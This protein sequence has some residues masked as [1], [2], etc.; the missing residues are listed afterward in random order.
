MEQL[1]RTDLSAHEVA[2]VMVIVG[3]LLVGRYA[4]EFLSS[5]VFNQ[6]E[7]QELREGVL[8]GV[9]RWL[10]STQ[11]FARA[12]AQLL[13]FKII[14]T[15]VDVGSS[16]DPQLKSN[17]RNAWYL[18][19]VYKYFLENSDAKRLREKQSQF[20]DVFDVEETCTPEG[21]SRLPIDM[22]GEVNPVTMVERIVDCLKGMIDEAEEEFLDLATP[23]PKSEEP[24]QEES[25]V[26]GNLQR[27]IVPVDAL[28]LAL[29][30]ARE[31][32][33]RNFAGRRKQELIVCA[34]LIDKAPNLG[35]LCRT[36]EIFAAKSL[37]VPDKNVVKNE[38]FT[39]LSVGA[40][41]WID[42]EECK[43]KVRDA[44]MFCS[45]ANKSRDYSRKTK[46]CSDS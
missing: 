10:S 2:S 13:A 38:V 26:E 34:A 9:V 1:Q 23:S 7:V 17:K 3:N 43:E 5:A 32:R 36:A 37:I 35:G 27:K 24:E 19:S 25:V 31:Q 45:L 21:L 20:F 11:S 30:T 33:L 46:I 18:L 40:T 14:P 16:G 42:I 39:A 4:D 8:F 6:S 22:S 29:E 15:V 12:I 41:D 28:N 44:G